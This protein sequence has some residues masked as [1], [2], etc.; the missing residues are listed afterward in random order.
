MLR[1]LACH[2]RKENFTS[3]LPEFKNHITICHHVLNTCD[4]KYSILFFQ[5][6]ALKSYHITKVTFICIIEEKQTEYQ[7]LTKKV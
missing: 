7:V 5:L 4:V 2:W 3:Y 6:A 1:S